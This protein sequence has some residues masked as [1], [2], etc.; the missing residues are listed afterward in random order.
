MYD[1]QSAWVYILRCADDSYYVGSH[2][3]PD[4]AVRVSGHNAG[5]D[6]KAYTYRRR[7]VE[8]AWPAASSSSATPSPS[9]AN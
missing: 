7:P 5:L 6:P 4:P 2:R 3:G 8:L 1:V 9:S